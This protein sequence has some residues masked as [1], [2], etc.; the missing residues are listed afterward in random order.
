MKILVIFS[1][2]TIGSRMSGESLVPD[3]STNYILLDR[4][5]TATGDNETQYDVL[6]PC[7]MLSENLSDKELNLII[8]S[9][10][11]N[12]E[13]GY[14]G[15]IVTHGTDT[16]QYTAA[17]L[18]YAFCDARI[19]ILVVSS[20]YPIS[21]IRAN[22]VDNFI[23]AV[24]FIKAK[25]SNGVFVSYKND[26]ETSVNIFVAKGLYLHGENTANLR[27]QDGAYA[28]FDDNFTQNFEYK[29]DCQKAVGKVKYSNNPE[30]L[31]ICAHP[32]DQFNYSL[33]NVKAVI[34]R[35]YHSGTLD[36]KNPKLIRF[37]KNAKELE[38]PVI[39]TG[40]SKEKNYESKMVYNELGIIPLENSAFPSVFMR[41]WLAVSMKENIKEALKKEYGVH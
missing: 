36:S 6:M 23:T 20:D 4:Y 18:Y 5:R 17:A 28:V 25:I 16:L 35:P 30:I 3:N 34:L 26:D 7:S 21:D 1:G 11:D 14:D 15:I 29:K 12:L 24:E 27:H 2:G 19:P 37:L 8:D 22:G 10:S 39:L 9:V 41:C 38:I 31:T 32:L 33:E 40:E 13:K